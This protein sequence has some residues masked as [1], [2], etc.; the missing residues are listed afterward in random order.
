MTATR[1]LAG[2]ALATALVAMS[3]ATAPL[4]AA[5]ADTIYDSHI[6]EQ[7]TFT[8]AQLPMVRAILSQSRQSLLAIFGKYGI[9]PY[10]RPNFDKLL[11]ASSELQA[12]QANEKR[13]MKAILSKD[14]YKLYL[15]LL[16]VTAARVIKATRNDDNQ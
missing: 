8:P 4:G 13:E 9:D 15:K 5:R 16:Q 2:R 7:M 11:E 1:I 14:Q 6:V 3:L 10:A 12:V